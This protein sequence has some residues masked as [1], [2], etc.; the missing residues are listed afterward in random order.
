MHFKPLILLILSLTLSLSLDLSDTE[1]LTIS[2]S[3]SHPEFTLTPSKKFALQFTS[4]PTTGNDWYLQNAEE[5]KASGVITFLNL[6]DNQGGEYVA[7]KHELRMVGSG[8]H[9]F[10]LLKSNELIGEVELKFVYKR[11]W[12]TENFSEKTVVLKVGN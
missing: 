3:D 1:V 4:N 6:V 9:T 10:F 5:A 7:D 11:I 2:R 12:E 8:G